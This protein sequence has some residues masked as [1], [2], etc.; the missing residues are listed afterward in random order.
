MDLRKEIRTI[1][2]EVF[3]EAISSEHFKDRIYDRLTSNLYT[4]P[5][6]NY[7]EVE[8]QIETLKLINFDPEDSYAIFLKKF[9]VTYSSKDPVTDIAS[10]GDEVW[11]VVRNNEITTIFFRNSHQKDRVQGV[12][13]ALTI[14]AL[15][16]YYVENDKNEDGT[17]DYA[18]N[19]NTSLGT[20]KYKLD[21]PI[22]DLN[23][24]RWYVDENGEQIIY[25]KNTKKTI[26]F[27]DLDEKHFEKV[28]NAVVSN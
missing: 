8:K 13:H 26:P 22:I 25:V 14:K 11:A 12:N 21:L 19:R 7:S 4:R 18:S 2:K 17:V 5:H 27:N 6:F 3:S 24:Q 20:N 23:G 10:V 9:P 15:Y 16:K 1:L 28:I